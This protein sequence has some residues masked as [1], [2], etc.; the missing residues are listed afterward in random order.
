MITVLTAL[1][2]PLVALGVK[3]A[4]TEAADIALSPNVSDAIELA[5]A[6]ADNSPDVVLVDSAF[7]VEDPKLLPRIVAE[8]PNCKPLVMVDHSDQE[9]TLRAMLQDQSD[10]RL[11]P[12]A[13]GRLRECCLVALK[14]AARGCIAKSSPP[15]RL[16]EATSLSMDKILSL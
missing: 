10:F 8:R 7:H 1:H 12:E 5:E 11:S 16:L 3:A 13:I 6:L 2:E 15:E 4:I 14:S 9:C